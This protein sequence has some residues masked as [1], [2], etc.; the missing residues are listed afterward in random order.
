MT[1]ESVESGEVGAVMPTGRMSPM[2]LLVPEVLI[3]KVVLSPTAF[4]L[5]GNN[6][7]LTASKAD[8]EASADAAEEGFDA[9]AVEIPLGAEGLDP[10]ETGAGIALEAAEDDVNEVD[11]EEDCGT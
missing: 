3:E 10:N 6:S 9:D 7:M 1:L 4:F 11:D 5:F 8:L 2:G